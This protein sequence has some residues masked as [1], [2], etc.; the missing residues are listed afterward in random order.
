MCLWYSRN[1]QEHGLI[2]FLPS[3]RFDES[4]ATALYLNTAAGLLLNMLDIRTALAN[5]LST[6]VES[7]NGL[8]VNW[9]ALVG[10]F[11]L[12]KVR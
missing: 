6:Q 7:R 4:R 9:D 11:A 8:Q 10:P 12:Y 3:A 2:T 5:N 1:M